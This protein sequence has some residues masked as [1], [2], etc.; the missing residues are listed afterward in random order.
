MRDIRILLASLSLLLATAAAP[1]FA[2]SAQE[3]Q[4]DPE[5]QVEQS[6]SARQE[7]QSEQIQL[8]AEIIKKVQSA[9][10]EKGFDPGPVDG[11]MGPKTEQALKQFQQ[12]NKLQVTGKPD[13]ATMK[14]LG[15][16]EPS[17]GEGP[18][19]DGEK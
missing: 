15:V 10:K 17:T 3:R 16:E 19:K 18:T 5:P 12:A 7:A 8:P 6:E 4:S 11:L 1:A 2:R 14:A 9:L 13:Q